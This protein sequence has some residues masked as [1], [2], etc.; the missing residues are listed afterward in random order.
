MNNE[1]MNELMKE[2]MSEWKNEWMNEWVSAWVIAWSGMELNCIVF[3]QPR[4][5]TDRL[6]R[7]PTDLLA[8]WVSECER[9]NDMKEWMNEWM[10]ERV[11]AWRKTD[12]SLTHS[13]THSLTWMNEWMDERTDGG[14]DGWLDGMDWVNERVTECKMSELLTLCMWQ[15]G[16]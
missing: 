5:L 11:K 9:G 15:V 8:N 12:D 6:T 4:P 16:S 14:M 2:W 1:P 13:L 7:R 3:N 10:N